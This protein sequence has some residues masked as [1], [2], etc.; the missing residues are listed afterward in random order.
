LDWNRWGHRIKWFL[1]VGARQIASRA[2]WK[3]RLAPMDIIIIL[4]KQ[5]LARGLKFTLFIYLGV[6]PSR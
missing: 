1:Q 4:E 5:T 3:A 6:F 2:G